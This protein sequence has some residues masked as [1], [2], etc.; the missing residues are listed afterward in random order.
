MNKIIPF[1][2]APKKNKTHRN[3]FNQEGQ[4]PIH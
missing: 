1:T 4:R 3:K 2:I